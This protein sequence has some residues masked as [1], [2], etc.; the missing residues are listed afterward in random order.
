MLALTDSALAR[1]AIA[2]TRID[3]RHRGRWLRE[4]AARFDPPVDISHIE[5]SPAARRQARV[6]Q[7]RRSG[8][9]CYTIEVPD[10]VAEG[11]INALVATEKLTDAEACNHAR[12][13]AELGR[14]LV[15][16]A[17]RWLR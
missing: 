16:W 9:R 17:Q 6:R 11:M 1:L 2:A 13:Q 3:P 4:V 5:K 8:T 14:M 15:D 10:I 12:V 7:R